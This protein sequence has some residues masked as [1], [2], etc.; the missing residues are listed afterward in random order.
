MRKLFHTE[1]N[2]NWTGAPRSPQRTWAEKDGRPGFPATRHSPTAT[3]A[4]FSK[5]SRM[6]FAN[7]TKLDRKSGGSPPQRLQN[8]AANPRRVPHISLFFREMWDTTN[9]DRPLPIEPANSS[10]E[11]RNGSSLS[12]QHY[13]VCIEA[14]SAQTRISRQN[15]S[16]R[17]RSVSHEHMNRAAPP[18][19]V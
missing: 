3:C 12:S 9:L 18:I 5:E 14:C 4:A 6:R 17:L 2:G 1:L 7:A 10:V 11:R 19:K 15:S 13:L 16:I 8:R